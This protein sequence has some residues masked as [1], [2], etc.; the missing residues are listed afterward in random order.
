MTK[1]VTEKLYKNIFWGFTPKKLI[2]SKKT[3]FQKIEV[4]EHHIF[5]K[6]L[7][8]DDIVQFCS[9][10]EHILHEALV[11]C[12]FFIKNNIK[13]ILIVGGGDLAIASRML[14]FKSVEK[15]TLIDIDQVVLEVSRKYFPEFSKKV[16][17]NSKV[18]IITD[19]AS[20]YIKKLG[21]N[22]FD[23]VIADTTD[24][25]GVGASLYSEKFIQQLF[26][27]T[28]NGGILMKLGGSVFL[29][30]KLLTKSK[31]LL[32]KVFGIDSVGMLGLPLNMYQG[33]LYA[34]FIATKNVKFS[35]RAKY[36]I[37][38]GFSWYS[39]EIHSAVFSIIK[40]L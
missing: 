18:E 19:D 7:L 4:Y 1:K 25:M 2:Y 36:K 35:F 9:Q 10:D 17:G 3:R 23:L 40:N 15:I 20:R 39:K 30:K 16:L 38:T 8:L 37:P 14:N 29:Q 22:E 27:I 5:G 24:D 32:Q 12:P 31:L 13:K 33:G 34:V 28:A 26:H 11:G 21:K 6:V